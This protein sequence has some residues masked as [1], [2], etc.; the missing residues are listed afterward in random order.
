MARTLNILNQDEGV[1]KKK[2]SKRGSFISIAIGVMI[3]VGALL[4]GLWGYLFYLSQQRSAVDSRIASLDT[5]IARFDGPDLRLYQTQR[6]GVR[7]LLRDHTYWTQV[8]QAFD[9]H[10]LSGVE[11]SSIT[12]SGE[13]SISTSA[14]ADSYDRA[15]EQFERF[16]DSEDFGTI[17]VP[18]VSAFSGQAQGSGVSFNMNILFNTRLLRK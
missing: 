7:D 5:N 13:G 8:L 4:A 12:L 2:K 3:L 6:D 15:A 10:V 9:D 17:R 14:R 18:N 16:R 11:L 1:I